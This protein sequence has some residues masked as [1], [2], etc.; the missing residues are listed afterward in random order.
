[1]VA[2]AG[3][4]Q[5][6]HWSPVA[7]LDRWKGRPALPPEDVTKEAS[8][9]QNESWNSGTVERYVCRASLNCHFIML[10][11]FQHFLVAPAQP[12]FILFCYIKNPMLCIRALSF[13]IR[14]CCSSKASTLAD[15][16]VSYLV[17][18]ATGTTGRRLAERT[19]SEWEW[20]SLRIAIQFDLD[21]ALC[22]ASGVAENCQE[23]LII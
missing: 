20:E 3:G 23:T 13:I 9:V 17:E 10:S 15:D 22:Y 8:S 2:S 11:I 1:M 14:F 4:W 6:L 18:V 19:I 21:R 5:F 12:K 16:I 7:E